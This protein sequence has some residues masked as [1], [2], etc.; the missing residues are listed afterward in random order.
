M[1]VFESSLTDEEK[2]EVITIALENARES[3]KVR[4]FQRVCYHGRGNA[5]DAFDKGFEAA[6]AYAAAEDFSQLMSDAE[7][8]VLCKHG[9]N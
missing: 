4:Y 5:A 2:A 7:T 1:D 9:R 6:V 8:A 3:A